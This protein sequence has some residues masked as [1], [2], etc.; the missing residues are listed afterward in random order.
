MRVASARLLVGGDLRAAADTSASALARF[1]GDILADGRRR[2]VGHAAPGATRGDP[3][4]TDGDPLHR[5]PGPRRRRRPDRRARGRGGGVPVPRSALAAPGHRPVPG[6]PPGRR[7]CRVPA[8]ARGPGRRARPRARPRTPSARAAD[9]RP[10]RRARRQRAP[11]ASRPFDPHAGNLP[12]MSV[13]L[14]GRDGDVDAVVALLERER[15]VELIGAGGVGKTALAIAAARTWSTTNPA[16][17]SGAWLARLEAAATADEVHDVLIA[18]FNVTGGEARCSNAS[19]PWRASWCSTT[20][21]MSRRRPR[22]VAT[23]VLDAAPGMR[24][25]CTSQVALDVDGSR[26][27]RARAA[28]THRCHRA[29]HPTCAAQ[30]ANRRAARRRRGPRALPLARRS[31]ARDRVGRGADQDAAHR[32]DHPPPRRP[33]RGPAGPDE[34]ETPNAGE[35]SRQR[36]GGATTC[37]S[38]TTSAGLWALATFAGAHRSPPSS[39]SSKR[40]STSRRRRPSTWSDDSPPDRW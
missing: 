35:R 1:V 13:E 8:R 30:R 17:P 2:R 15:L 10:R 9:P 40:D 4:A 27:L 14:V 34:H 3:H 37:C 29:V 7:P 36:S 33:L 25:L 26:P 5:A 21:S 20:A 22:T 24:I 39:S 32:R 23:R 6:R 12:S 11:R 38:P 28:A 18:A 19:G 16:A 31:P